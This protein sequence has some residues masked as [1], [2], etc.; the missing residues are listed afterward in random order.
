MLIIFD[1]D[2]V[3]MDSTILHTQAES[4]CLE[5]IGIK[6]SAEEMAERFSG[7]ADK[8]VF[9]TLEKENGLKL[10]ENINQRFLDE[11]ISLFKKNLKPMPHMEKT[12]KNLSNIPYCIA[13]GTSIEMLNF[14]L[15]ET[16][17]INYFSS[18]VYSAE[19]VPRGKPFPDLFLYAAEQMNTPP[20]TCIVIEDSVAGIKAATASSMKS[21]GFTGGSHCGPKHN[22]KLKQAG[23]TIT[24]NNMKDLPQIL[25]EL[26]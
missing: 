24:F 15:S 1:C 12:L 8:D 22:Q 21:L 2:G 14:M 6:I 5:K 25:T 9:K 18:N 26:K 10:P 3:I 19:M 11:K 23:A 16:N 7:I 13:S 4:L 20:Q 17:L